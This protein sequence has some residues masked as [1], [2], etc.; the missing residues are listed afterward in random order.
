MKDDK[1]IQLE[2]KQDT[3]LNRKIGRRR[4]LKGMGLFAGSTLFPP[5]IS[6]LALAAEKVKFGERVP[7]VVATYG[8]EE[9]FSTEMWR[10]FSDDLGKIGIKVRLKPSSFAS[11]M[12]AARTRTYGDLI[13]NLNPGRPER[14]D[15]T[16]YLFS[17]AHSSEA[18]VEGRNVGNYVNPEYDRLVNAQD[19]EPD[20]EKR[21]KL[22]FKAQEVLANDYYSITIFPKI[23]Q[24]YN[25]EDWEGVVPVAGNGVADTLY[26]WT[27][28]N[29]KSKTGKKMVILGSSRLIR[30]TNILADT[31]DFRNHGRFIYD[32]F[33]KLDKDLNVVPWAAESWKMLDNKTWDIKLR[34]GMKWHDG[35]PVTAEDVKF[36][37]DYLL[38]W[39]PGLFSIVYRPI[40]K[41]EILDSPRGLLRFH[42]NRPLATFLTVVMMMGIIL[43]KHIWENIMKEQ[44]VSQPTQVLI[45]K[46]IGSGFFKFGHYKRDQELLLM[47]NK[48]HFSP[49]KIEGLLITMIPSID[50]IMG[51]LETK[52][53]DFAINSLIP[54]QANRLKKFKHLSVVETDDIGYIKIDMFLAKMPWKD[55]ELRRALHHAIDKEF[56]V[57]TLWEG[58]GVLG[59]NTLIP[60]ANKFWYNPNLP[61]VKFDLDKARKILMDAG[62]GWD[63]EGR[64][65]YPDPNDPNYSK[66]IDRVIAPR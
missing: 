34:P 37:F 39:K 45:D 9:T 49:P 8:I 30:S 33:V 43:P 10:K 36:T 64:L 25:C 5:S 28:L 20:L 48:E 59:K 44:G 4:L 46:P 29:L 52:E 42:L 18:V 65:L 15:P 51:R 22:V 58:A 6:R 13:S 1:K 24:A 31:Q 14:V 56:V 40:E 62:Y 57:N 23:I 11:Q 7:E 38:Q 53:I 41:V 2:E 32:T 16:E 55:I 27:Y 50:G 19:I 47:A 12:N 26:P 60:P 54:S 66:R 17:R 63:D 21:Q 61:E 35:K 3:M